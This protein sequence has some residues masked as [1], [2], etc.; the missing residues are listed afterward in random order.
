MKHTLAV[1]FVCFV[2]LQAA[3]ADD[4]QK[5]LKQLSRVNAMASDTT[6]RR[7]V[8]ITI[9]DMTT[10][11][12]ADLIR[13]RKAMNLNYGSLFLAQQLVSDG[14]AM[15]DLGA[16]LKQGK[17]AYDVAN[18]QHADWKLLL[19][20]AKKLNGK[21]E[22]GLFEHFADSRADDLRDKMDAY[23]LLADVVPADADVA[24]ADIDEAADVYVR[25]RDLAYQRAGRRAGGLNTADSMNFRRDQV[26]EG[27]P[28][29]TQLGIKTTPK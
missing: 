11:K 26:R 21:I 28:D 15:A 14:L 22:R 12:R 16:Q 27:A 7:V 4:Q 29:A 10:V 18:A 25:E 8:S 2:S 5:T 9:A 3:Q 13:Q 1:L 20:E 19:G 24:R 17:S 6:G 23:S